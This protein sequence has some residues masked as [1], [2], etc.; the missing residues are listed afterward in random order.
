MSVERRDDLMFV[1]PPGPAR[2]DAARG[3]WVLSRYADVAAALAEPRLELEGHRA[4]VRSRTQ[5]A[6]SPATLKAW[7][8]QAEPVAFRMVNALPAAP[9]DV[10]HEF[11][12]PWSAALAGMVTGAD[13]RDERLAGLARRIS[14]ATADPGDPAAKLAAAEAEK[15]LASSMPPGSFPMAAAAFVALSQTLP[16]FLGNAW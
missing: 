12:E 1:C 11:A 9:V 13:A 8:S 15:E 3:A 2:F 6:L 7:Q 14:A 10:L 16:A 5:A 4:S